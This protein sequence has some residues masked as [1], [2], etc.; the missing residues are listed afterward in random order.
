[1]QDAMKQMQART[2]VRTF[3]P[4][5]L[6]PE[7]TAAM[8]AFLAEHTENPFGARVRFALLQRADIEGPLGTYGMLRGMQAY[9]AGCVQKGDMDIEGFGYA[10]E[11]AVLFATSLGIGT[12]W[13]GGSFKRSTFE[14]ILKPQD[15]EKLPAVSPL[16]YAA[17]KQ[18]L[19]ERMMVR[20]VKTRQRKPFD[21][22]FFDGGFSTPL[23]PGDDAVS[24]CLQMV[25]IGPSA[26]NRQPWRAVR[27]DGAVHFYLNAEPGYMGNRVSGF[28]MQRLDMGIAACHFAL[29]AAELSLPGGIRVQDPGIQG[30][31]GDFSYSFSWS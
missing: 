15:G 28:C 12:C 22:L 6:T 20:A 2:S 5:P 10:F 30:V 21:T 25:R 29:A 1:M 31:P 13:L 3:D 7:H 16:G 18:S 11:H 17:A 27:A 23:A 19:V 9:F 8:E 14:Q 26:S 24:Q 4:R